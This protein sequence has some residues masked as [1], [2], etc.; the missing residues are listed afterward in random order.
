VS[1]SVDGVLRTAASHGQ[2]SIVEA[3]LDRADPTAWDHAAFLDAAAEGHDAVVQTLLKDPR[4]DPTVDEQWALSIASQNGHIAVVNVLLADGRVTVQ[5][6]ALQR[7]RRKGH[8]AI[9]EMLENAL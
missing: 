1:P 8:T 7:A 9:V 6:Q 2:L 5:E 4:V 3:I